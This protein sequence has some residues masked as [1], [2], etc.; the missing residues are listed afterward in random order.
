MWF[1]CVTNNLPHSVVGVKQEAF[2]GR[3]G[4]FLHL[5]PFCDR[6]Q[7]W[8]PF[9][10]VAPIAMPLAMRLHNSSLQERRLFS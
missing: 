7:S 3:L 2:T 5:T 1:Y 10:S 4:L 9:S 8:H 6:L